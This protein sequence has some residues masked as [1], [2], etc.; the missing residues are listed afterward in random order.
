M[1]S[2]WRGFCG[3]FSLS[4]SLAVLGCGTGGTSYVRAVN[5]SQGLSNFT[6]QAGVTGIAANLPF[7]TEGV[8]QPGQVTT[9]D[10]TGAYRP[11]GAGT[12]QNLSIYS[13]PGTNLNVTKQTFLK[14][15]RYTIVT[16]APAP[17]VEFQTLTDDNVAP[18]GGSYK[19]RV[20]DTSTQAGAVDV[21][22]TPLGG[23]IT[24]SPV[25]ANMQLQQVTTPYLQLSPGTLEV[26]VTLHGGNTV[27]TSKAFS[28]AAGKIYS[29]FF[30]DP[31]IRGG[32]NY[33]VLIVNDPVAG[34]STN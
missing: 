19:L 4:I 14:Q 2:K 24:G 23:G 28:P 22:I 18:S 30:L 5:A 34:S 3:V 13:K 31:P 27:L 26:Q 12:L 29:I 25:V 6:I 33:G 1:C 16:L 32:S 15:T 11:I 8:Q 9:T 21:Y 17:A 7:G 20:M 10:T